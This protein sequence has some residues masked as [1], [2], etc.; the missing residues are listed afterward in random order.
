M[1]A[2]LAGAPLMGVVGPSGSG[3]SSA[4][5]AGLMASLAAGVLP[6]SER[7]TPV[8][9]RPGERP[10][11]ALEQAATDTAP[12]GRRIVA[13]DQFEEVFTACAEES[14]RAAFADALVACAR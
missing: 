3:K 11:R 2:R 4:L 5:R 7:W 14:E 1:V 12:G 8:L 6:G 13:V 9:L 10:M